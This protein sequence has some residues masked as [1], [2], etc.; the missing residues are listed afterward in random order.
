MTEF[1]M[2]RNTLIVKIDKMKEIAARTSTPAR[3]RQAARELAKQYIID[4]AF[5]EHARPKLAFELRAR[6]FSRHAVKA[7]GIFD[8]EEVQQAL[9]A[10]E[11]AV[12]HLGEALRRDLERDAQPLRASKTPLRDIFMSKVRSHVRTAPINDLVARGV[13]T[14][15]E[16]GVQRVPEPTSRR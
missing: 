9:T 7:K 14:K 5:H 13:L 12:G 2:K 1:E 8:N 15:L 16:Q 10:A 6:A 3:E 4:L 11:R